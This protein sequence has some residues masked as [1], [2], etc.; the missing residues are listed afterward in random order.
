MMLLVQ[1]AT[2]GKV[3]TGQRDGRFISKKKHILCNM[4]VQTQTKTIKKETHGK[5][6]LFP[7]NHTKKH[8]KFLALVL[9]E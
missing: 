3:A 4:S 8:V 9:L 1:K 7:K 5:T 2:L 6:P